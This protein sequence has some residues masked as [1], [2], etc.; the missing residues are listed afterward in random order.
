MDAVSTA[1]QDTDVSIVSIS[2]GQAES[3][4]TGQTLSS[5]NQI[6]QD[7]VTLGKTVFV[8]AGDN[9]SSDGVTDGQNHVDFPASSPFVFACGGTT[10]QA[11]NGQITSE[12][13]WN[14]QASGNG[15]TGGGVSNFF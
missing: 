6:L 14:E 2:W 12:T 3:E 1:I 7:A 9:G 15:A 8:A 13:V 4:Y 11:S 10:L 5:F